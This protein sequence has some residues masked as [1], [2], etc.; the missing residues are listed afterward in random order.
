MGERRMI[1]VYRAQ[2]SPRAH[3]LRAALEAAGIR[4]VV[5]GD[6]LQGV[7]GD[8]D[9]STAPRILV[10]ERD[11]REARALLERLEGPAVAGPRSPGP[12]PWSYRSRRTE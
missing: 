2:D 4:A 11:A 8:G 1:E 12:G 10:D 6:R 9:W 5:D 7:V 3:L